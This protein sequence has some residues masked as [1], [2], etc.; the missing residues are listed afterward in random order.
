MAA[1]SFMAPFW[2][3]GRLQESHLFQPFVHYLADGN[4]LG[5]WACYQI[6]SQLGGAIEARG[7][8]NDTATGM[9]TEM[10]L[11]LWS[12]TPR[13]WANRCATGSNWKVSAVTGTRAPWPLS[14]DPGI[15]R[16]NLWEKMKKLGIE[17]E[18]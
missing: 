7:H 16:K 10:P 11:K 18:N 2:K 6:V 3:A 12:K 8:D 14:A 9:I 17:K 5:L 15:S 4:S 1:D 13:S